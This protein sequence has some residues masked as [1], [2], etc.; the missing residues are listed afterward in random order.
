MNDPNPRKLQRCVIF[1][2]IYFF[3]RRGRENLYEMQFDQFEVG[4]EP[5]RTQ[6]VFQTIHEADK[7]HDF[8]DT[9]ETNP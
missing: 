7:N 6:Y 8:E 3:C 5:D 4:T 2:T 9:D 1:Y